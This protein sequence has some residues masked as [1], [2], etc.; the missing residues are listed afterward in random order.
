MLYLSAVR[1]PGWLGDFSGS[2][3][4]PSFGL[5]L[6][7]GFGQCAAVRCCATVLLLIRH[8]PL[9]DLLAFNKANASAAPRTAKPPE[10]PASSVWRG[11]LQDHQDYT[12]QRW[13]NS[14][15]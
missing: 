4:N 6:P 10:S 14:L 9:L 3:H 11:N 2:G 5:A 8:V 12:A 13:K 15:E 1:R 7:F